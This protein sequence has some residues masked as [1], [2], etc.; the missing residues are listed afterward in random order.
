MKKV[1]HVISGHL[2]DDKR[3]LGRQCSALIKYGFDVYI[4]TNDGKG[5][6]VIDGIKIISTS[7]FYTNRIKVILNAKSIFLNDAL[8]I[9][10]DIY[11][12]HGPE[13]IPLG[14][15]L[16]KMG[17]VVIYD[18]HEDLSGQI[19]EKK[20]IP[21]I[22]RNLLSIFSK[23][24]FNYTLYRFN[25]LITVTDHIA[26]KLKK[27][28][29]NITVIPNFPLIS[30]IGKF[31]LEEYL[32]RENVVCYTG[33]VYDQ[34]NQESIIKAINKISQVEYHIAGSINEKL[35]EKMMALNTL[36]KL[37]YFGFLP[38][39]DLPSFYNCANIGIIV[40]DYEE[41]M[42]YDHGTLGSNKF[43]EYM[44]AG[45]PVICTDYKLWNDI[46]NKYECGITVNPTNVSQIED[47]I[48]FLIKDKSRAYKM[49]Q[50][51]RKAI[52]E[53]FNW[54]KVE[55]LYVNLF[56]KYANKG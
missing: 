26:D 46:I 21:Y 28:N 14:L 52:L 3:I 53:E 34:S 27:Y 17:K 41:N 56:L 55:M 42:G 45:L 11:Q 48:R 7:K 36:N 32:I 31:S 19:L 10:A 50:N 37:N 51:G 49:G 1:C 4:L 39:S 33:T 40:Q 25:E 16:K 29:L 20:W 22:F 15:F 6:E 8:D 47:A 44:E 35:F 23:I 43:F 12:L 30:S 13:L 24:Y 54:G 18:A 5:A 38:K 2:R 9:N